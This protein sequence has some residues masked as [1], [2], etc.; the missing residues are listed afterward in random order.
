MRLTELLRGL[1]GTTKSE[2]DSLSSFTAIPDSDGLN[3]CLDRAALAEARAGRGSG[4]ERIQLVVL[5]ML[6]E[7]GIA[8][9]IANG[10]RLAASAACA[11]D[12]EQAEILRLAPRFPGRFRAETNGHTG[13]AGFRVSVVAVMSDGE[14]PTRVRGPFL[15]LGPYERYLLSPAELIALAA[16]QKHSSLAAHERGVAENLR[17]MAALQLAQRSGM[18]IDLGVFEKLDVVVPEDIGVVATRL[19]DGSLQL[20]PTLG[21][22]STPEQ[23][24][25]RWDQIDMTAEGGVLRI[26][27]RIV[28]LDQKRLDGVKEVLACRRIPAE[29]VAE[30]MTTPTA[31]LDAALVNLDLGF[32]VRVLGVGKFEHMQ[33][34]PVDAMK[35]DWFAL[36][37]LPSPP[38][39]LGR[40]LTTHEEI[41][42]FEETLSA[43]RKQG[44]D[45]V[46]FA[47][48]RIDISDHAAIEQALSGARL[49]LERSPEDRVEI[50]PDEPPERVTVL[51]AEA[52]R[53]G[54]LLSLAADAKGSAEPDLE[55]LARPPFPHQREGIDWI[56]SLLDAALHGA[57]EDMYR[58]QGAL[59]ADDM[60]LGKT[61]MTLVAA[62]IYLRRQSVLGRVVKPVLVVAPLSLL[63]NWEDEVDKTFLASPFRDVVV[64]QAGRDLRKYRTGGVRDESGQP[65]GEAHGHQAGAESI[66]YALNVGPEAGPRRLDLDRRLVLATYQ[67]LRDYQLSLCQI[68]WGLVVF[69]EAQNIK[70]PNALQTRA[71]KGLKADFKLLATGTPVENSLGDFWCLMDTAQPGLL[72]SWRQ[73]RDKWIA[74]ILE[75]GPEERDRVRL[76][77]G[78]SLREAVGRFMLRRTKEDQLKGLPSKTIHCGV[79]QPQGGAARHEPLLGSVMTDRQLS[80][81]DGVLEQYRKQRATEDMRGRALAVLSELREISLHPRLRDEHALLTRSPEE[82]RKRMGESGKLGKLLDVLDSVRTKN[83]KAILFMITK[84]LQRTLKLLLDTV[85]G[86]DVAVINGDTAAISSKSDGLSR[87]Q[88]IAAFEAK[89]GFNLIIMSPIAA[90]VGLTVVGANH[91]V[92]VERHWNPAKEAQASDRVYRI[93]QTRAVHVHVPA[94]LHPKFDSFDVHLDRLL[95]GKLMLKDA[96][97]TPEAVSE[98]EIARALGLEEDG[99]AMH[100][101]LNHPLAPITLSE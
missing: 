43:A 72:G 91:V 81:Y 97:V 38:E 34:G 84:R 4:L 13:L 45:T 63:E 66:R 8:E 46:N 37:A 22:G 90:G 25:R 58:L 65:L 60:G 21:D 98:L 7:Q 68:D 56:T 67:T 17:L 101:I 52:E 29:R 89:P 6:E 75:A 86:L 27:D 35:C 33:F 54:N 93:G 23:L 53:R 18:K 95:Q 11:L 100:D 39:A 62:S 15:E 80:A 82:A 28:L 64:L 5:R 61:Y 74:P 99:G 71:A 85:Y 87:K 79:P 94:S 69:D 10:Y 31:F 48:E 41:A 92:H 47:G 42:Q 70:N 88:L 36:D 77:V 24:E 76:E 16:L 2:I 59:L 96:V 26:Q 49:K 57:R 20:A 3:V 14:A 51:I 1:L 40:L 30:F 83:E 78:S 19:P 73:F 32:S 12:D 9:G 50:P 44:A 55:S